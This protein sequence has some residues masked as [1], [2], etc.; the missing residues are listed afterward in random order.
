MKKFK[1][2]RENK[3]LIKDYEA[4]MAKGDKTD[5]NAIDYLGSMAKYKKY[6][7]DDLRKIIGDHKRKGVFKR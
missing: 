6:S 1:E 5:R 3:N 7:Y 4:Y 2:F